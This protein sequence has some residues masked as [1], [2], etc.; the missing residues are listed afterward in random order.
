MKKGL[1]KQ[2]CTDVVS[3]GFRRTNENLNLLLHL[4]V[5]FRWEMGLCC[6]LEYNPFTVVTNDNQIRSMDF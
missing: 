4:L 1:M 5:V 6:L 2:T 3:V